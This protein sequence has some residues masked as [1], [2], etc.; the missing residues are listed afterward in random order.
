V[1]KL[2]KLIRNKK[3]SGTVPDAAHSLATH[4]EAG[5]AALLDLA[6]SDEFD[7]SDKRTFLTFYRLARTTLESKKLGRPNLREGEMVR[8][9]DKARRRLEN[10][11]G[12]L[13]AE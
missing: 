5:A 7:Q 6:T 2:T 12:L 4:G 9:S 3:S 11:S 10:G 8:R 13:G 1:G